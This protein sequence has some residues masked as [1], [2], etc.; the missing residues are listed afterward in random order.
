MNSLSLDGDFVAQSLTFFHS[1]KNGMEPS[2]S[3]L[4]SRAMKYLREEHVRMAVESTESAL[5][6]LKAKLS[7]GKRHK[8][9]TRRES[10]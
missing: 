4:C 1:A 8:E 7:C 3:I 6:E 9:V 5:G 2:R 10:Y